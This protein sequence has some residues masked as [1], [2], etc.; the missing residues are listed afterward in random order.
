MVVIQ[1]ARKPNR[2]R[3]KEAPGVGIVVPVAVVV[4]AGF[5]VVVLALEADR[6][7]DF[8]DQGANNVAVGAVC[9]RPDKV[10][11]GV[12][13]FLGSTQMVQVVIVNAGLFG[14]AAVYQRQGFKGIGL[15]DVNAVL[16]A[17]FLGDQ[18]VA[19]FCPTSLLIMQSLRTCLI[20]LH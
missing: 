18:A 17:G 8:V 1:S 14:A 9:Y 2:V 19:L 12:G 15:V 6:V 13:E 4:Q 5:R 7:V 10:A 16:V 20:T 11:L 3:G